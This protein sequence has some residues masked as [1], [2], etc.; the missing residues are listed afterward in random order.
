MPIQVHRC[1]ENSTV[2]YKDV[3]ALANESLNKSIERK[4]SWFSIIFDI[5]M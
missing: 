3:H 4:K 1:L 2:L 5:L